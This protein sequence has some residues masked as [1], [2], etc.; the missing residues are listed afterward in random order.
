MSSRPT[1]YRRTPDLTSDTTVG[2]R[3][4]SLAVE[5]TPAGLLTT[6]TARSAST[7]TAAPST[8]T[9]STSVTSRA[10]SVTVAPLTV[11]RCARTISSAARREATPAVA[12][13][14]AS[15]MNGLPP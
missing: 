6:Y 3:W 10:G 8:V 7:A 1:G 15:R 14:L 13:N 12:R 5:T 4:G 9:V 11:T 2:R